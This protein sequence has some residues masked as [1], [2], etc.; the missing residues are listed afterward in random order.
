MAKLIQSSRKIKSTCICIN[1]STLQEFRKNQRNTASPQY[2]V[3]VRNPDI[4]VAAAGNPNVPPL[5]LID[6]PEP[7]TIT[8]PFK[9]KFSHARADLQSVRF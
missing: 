9:T 3:I 4:P 6:N 7:P 2:L 5:I 8:A 1:I